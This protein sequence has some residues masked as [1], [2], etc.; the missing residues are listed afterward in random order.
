MIFSPQRRGWSWAGWF[1]KL[2]TSVAVAVHGG[3]VEAGYE[4]GGGSPGFTGAE[5]GVL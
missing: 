4:S 1:D 2:T 3:L 5:E